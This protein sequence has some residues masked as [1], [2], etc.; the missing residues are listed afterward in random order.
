MPSTGTYGIPQRNAL[1]ASEHSK[2]LRKA[3]TAST[4]GTTIEWY[5][6]FIHGTAAGLIFGKL[7][8]PNEDPLT[9]TLAALALI[10]LVSQVARSGPRFSATKVGLDGFCI[11]RLRRGQRHRSGPRFGGEFR[12]LIA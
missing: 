2:Q 3:V 12:N 9:G 6:F 7:Y 1:S 10:S 11:H 4:I 5:N 8:F